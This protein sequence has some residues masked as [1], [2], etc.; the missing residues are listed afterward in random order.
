LRCAGV[1]AAPCDFAAEGPGVRLGAGTDPVTT[2]DPVAGLDDRAVAATC[3]PVVADESPGVVPV[4]PGPAGLGPVPSVGTAGVGRAR[5]G[6]C[7]G[8]PLGSETGS[9]RP[10]IGTP[11][12]TLTVKS[13]T[14]AASSPATADKAIRVARRRVPESSTNTASRRRC[15]PIGGSL[16][17]LG[18]G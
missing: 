16:R 15:W 11:P 13:N 1:V 8:S 6:E 10:G 7:A 3:D 4:G 18:C 9:S 2:E 17:G 12:R 14:P 5:P